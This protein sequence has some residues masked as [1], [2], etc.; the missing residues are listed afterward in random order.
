MSQ[1]Q[2]RTIR[3][4]PTPDGWDV[5]LY[6]QTANGKRTLAREQVLTAELSAMKAGLLKLARE[7][8]FIT[9]PP[10]GV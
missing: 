2:H 6:A 1:N 7:N 9:R 4:K 3:V 10:E 5:T 8:G